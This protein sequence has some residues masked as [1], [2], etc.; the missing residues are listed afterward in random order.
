MAGPKGTPGPLMVEPIGTRVMCST[1]PATTSWYPPAMIPWAANC[2]ACWEEPHWRSMV[3]AGT[4]SGSPAASQ[5]LRATFTDCSPIWDTQP[6]ITSST[7]A[8]STPLRSTSARSAAAPRSTACTPASPPLRRPTGVRT[9]PT[10]TGSSSDSRS[11]MCCPFSAVPW[12]RRWHR[13]PRPSTGHRAAP[14]R[15]LGLLDHHPLEAQLLDRPVARVAV[16]GGDGVDH[17]HALDDLAEDG[18]LAVQPG[19][20]DLGDEELGAVGV[21]PGVGHGQVPRPVEAVGAADLVLELV[22]G[23]APSVPERVA[24]LDHE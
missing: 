18:V 5:A 12:N 23:A 13:P 10:I 6:R 2:T 22:A 15:L 24:A 20:G 16:D 9:A 11:R 8:G 1:P 19:G 14:R 21:G 3:V 17:V 4:S 7:S